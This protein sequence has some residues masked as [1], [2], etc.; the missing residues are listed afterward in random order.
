LSFLGIGAAPNRY[1]LDG[2]AR[3]GGGKSAVI[4]LNTNPEQIV[5]DAVERMHRA[6]LAKI[7]LQWGGLAVHDV[8][9][10]KIPDLWAGAPV[11]LF[12]KYAEGGAGKVTAS[13]TADGKPLSFSVDVS[14]PHSDYR[15]HDVLPQIWARQKIDD[16]SAQM[17]DADDTP[18]IEEITRLAL[19]YHLMSPYTS[20]VAIDEAELGA[21]SDPPTPPRRV[22]VP[23]PLPEGVSYAGVFGGDVVTLTDAQAVALPTVVDAPMAKAPYG[24]RAGQA[25]VALPKAADTAMAPSP[26]PPKTLGLAIPIAPV[27]ILGA[28]SGLIGG[29]STTPMP[30]TTYRMPADERGMQNIPRL[31][32]QITAGVRSSGVNYLDASAVAGKSSATYVAR[33]TEYLRADNIPEEIIPDVEDAMT[34]VEELLRANNPEAAFRQAQHAL[35]LTR[36][37]GSRAPLSAVEALV[38]RARQACLTTYVEAL[39]DL[40]TRLTLVIRNKSLEEAL[41]MIAAESGVTLTVG[42]GAADARALLEV[43]ELRV[44]YLDLRR[45]TVAQAL[46]WMLTPLML[47]WRVD[48]GTVVI[49]SM[50]RMS[51]AT[52]WL[53]NVSALT[54]PTPDELADDAG[55]KAAANVLALLLQAVRAE[56]GLSGD[57]PQQSYTAY[58]LDAGHIMVYGDRDAHESAA[59]LL[60]ALSTPMPRLKGYEGLQLITAA[61]ADAYAKSAAERRGPEVRLAMIQAMHDW[62]WALMADAYRGAVNVEA[63][64]RL[65]AAWISPEM[66]AVLSGPYRLIALRSA[67]AISRAARRLPDDVELNILARQT[68]SKAGGQLS[69]LIAALGEQ[70]DDATRYL[71][72]LYAT[73]TARTALPGA[74]DPAGPV[75]QATALLTAMKD[76][77]PYRVITRSLLAPSAADT[78][79]LARFFTEGKL[80]GADLII[81]GVQAAAQTR[82]GAWAAAR[83]ALPELLGGQRL[84]G[85]VTLLANRMAAAYEREWALRR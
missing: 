45:A 26:A 36:I 79:A 15:Q 35:F 24:A 41:R 33:A 46:E 34:I 28:L 59:A 44:P 43:R 72:L 25:G 73:L 1:L 37:A 66:D 6:Q 19:D 48:D 49:D 42:D 78:N 18:V 58:Y 77:D 7:K 51:G 39:P 5:A 70:P 16:L 55:A 80:Q 14:L 3:Q 83:R 50:R 21:H 76:Q 61:R 69:A 22:A 12:G 71:C 63:L 67:W 52:A 40:D 57:D 62:S 32:G 84:D 31:R 68:Y 75:A 13:G 27:A 30:T 64:T 47:S 53:Y 56:I 11:V 85:H 9:P 29:G 38:T 2:V 17:V 54:T 4:D 23:V 65:Q 20:L 60:R 74:G 82:G 10:R 8:L 81:L